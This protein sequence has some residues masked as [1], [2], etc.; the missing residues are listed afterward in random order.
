MQVVEFVPWLLT[1]Q[2]RSFDNGV[3]GYRASRCSQV[4]DSRPRVS[5]PLHGEYFS[6]V[7]K[8]SRRNQTSGGPTLNK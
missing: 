6:V 2:E 4:W 7:D 3:V 1:A 5:C 8:K